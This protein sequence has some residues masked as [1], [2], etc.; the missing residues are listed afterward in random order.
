MQGRSGDP[1]A[2]GADPAS[3]SLGSDT[4]AGEAE[5]K[6]RRSGPLARVR[7]RHQM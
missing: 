6:E 5:R 7:I 4:A 1:V 3:A 2:G